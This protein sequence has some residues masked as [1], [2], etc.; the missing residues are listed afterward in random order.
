VNEKLVSASVVSASQYLE[1]FKSFCSTVV[2]AKPM[3]EN[4]QRRRRLCNISVA[5]D[6]L[7]WLY[8]RAWL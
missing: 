5:L 2:L 4:F 6:W 1:D 7:P 8:R 3:Q